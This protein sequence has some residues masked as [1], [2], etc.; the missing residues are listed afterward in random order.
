MATETFSEQLRNDK[1]RSQS[2]KKSPQ[3]PQKSGQRY[4]PYKWKLQPLIAQNDIYNL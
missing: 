3:H 4:T 2:D 1:L